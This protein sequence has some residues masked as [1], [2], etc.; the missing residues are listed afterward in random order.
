MLDIND[1]AP[2]ITSPNR[3]SVKE[4]T[5]NAT[6]VFVVTA[7]DRDTGINSNV[8]YALAPLLDL[9]YPFL[10]DSKTGQLKVNSVLRRETIASYSLSITA[11]DGGTPAL[12]ATQM[13]TITVEDVNN[14][15]PVFESSVY[16]VNVKEDVSIGTSLL[17]V[18]ATDVDDDVNGVVRYFIVSG[19][20]TLDFVLDM[21][22]GVLRL[23]KRLDYERLKS[24]TL[25]IRAEDS[26]VEKSLSST[27]TVTVNV[28]DVNDFQPVFDDSPYIAYVLEGVTTVVNVTTVT[29]RDE[30]SPANNQVFYQLRDLSTP[31]IFQIE[32]S[33]GRITA[34]TSLDRETM[35]MYTLTVIAQD[36][37][38]CV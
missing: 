34:V 25:V 6:V 28:Q 1:C 15:P 16:Q 30:D 31:G 38:K 9:G 17:R 13:L 2:E 37:G 24:Y 36:S 21:A 14:N 35:P 20:E 22:S 12:T 4:E 11:R 32:F 5:P 10:L 29:A 3:T 18:K 26:G 19:D 7:V 8:T 23:Q 27:A 33:T